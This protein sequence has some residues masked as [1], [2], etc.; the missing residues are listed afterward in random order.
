MFTVATGNIH[1]HIFVVIDLLLFFWI[2]YNMKLPKYLTD[3]IMQ[4]ETHNM[5]C[6]EYSMNEI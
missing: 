2:R 3:S 1:V 5:S 4:V 6:I